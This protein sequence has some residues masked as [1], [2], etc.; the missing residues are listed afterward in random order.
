MI[1]CFYRCRFSALSSAVPPPLPF[2]F[3]LHSLPLLLRFCFVVMAPSSSLP[4]RSFS[5]C[6]CSPSP[7]DRRY[8]LLHFPLCFSLDQFSDLR[9]LFLI[10]LPAIDRGSVLGGSWGGLLTPDRILPGVFSFMRAPAYLSRV[11]YY[12]YLLTRH[13]RMVGHREESVRVFA[14]QRPLA[15]LQRL[16]SQLHR[17]L[18]VS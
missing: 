14:S 13:I 4:P 5:F 9:F 16:F 6:C 17:I 8:Y 10:S 15:C 18:P 11:L 3:M 7:L 12:F 2:L 1:R